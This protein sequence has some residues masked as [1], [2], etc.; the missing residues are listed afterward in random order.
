[1]T[2]ALFQ[3]H[4][5]L[6][7]G[8]G[9]LQVS[10]LGTGFPKASLLLC[11][12]YWITGWPTLCLTRDMATL[13]FKVSRKSGAYIKPALLPA[14]HSAQSHFGLVDGVV[15]G[16]FALCIGGLIFLLVQL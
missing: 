11:I 3:V 13:A 15:V 10:I 8:S 12:L 7:T 4:R 6:P 16:F 5:P 9:E 2:G 1:M 14:N